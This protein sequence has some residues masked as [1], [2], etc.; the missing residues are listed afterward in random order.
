MSILKVKD[1]KGDIIDIP[2]I[3]GYSAYQLAVA[4]G[5]EGTEEEWLASLKGEP[6]DV[7]E[8]LE[9]AAKLD[10]AVLAEAQD[11]A[12]SKDEAIADAK[13]VGEDAAAALA[14]YQVTN[15]A[16]VNANTTAINTLNGNTAVTG[17][18]DNKIA[19]AINDFAVNISDDGTVNTYKELID[20]AAT[21]GA[22]FTELVGEVTNNTA[23]IN[24]NARDIDALQEKHAYAHYVLIDYTSADNQKKA[25][26]TTLL[27]TQTATSYETSSVQAEQLEA[28][29]SDLRLLAGNKTGPHLMASGSFYGPPVNGGAT[30]GYCISHIRNALTDLGTK[31]IWLIGYDPDRDVSGPAGIALISIDTDSKGTVSLRDFVYQLM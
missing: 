13:Q 27:V 30:R 8:A 26:F 24:N 20:Y 10:V 12:D 18:V 16:A 28:F 23:A 11:Y 29:W 31:Q 5:F 2:A 4:N 7:N 17:S 14:E 19:K 25:I 22:E 1:T 9:A 21:H 3:R 6:G 15:D